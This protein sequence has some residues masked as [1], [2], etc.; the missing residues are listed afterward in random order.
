[1]YDN[2]EARLTAVE[3]EYD[4]PA[5]DGHEEIHAADEDV[6]EI[7]LIKDEED[8]R[9]TYA[10]TSELFGQHAIQSSLL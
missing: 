1:M 2:S 3:E 8:G 9:C 4:D 5:V 6:E 7:E 10:R